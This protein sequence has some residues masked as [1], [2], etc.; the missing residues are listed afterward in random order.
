[1]E[2]WRGTRGPSLVTR[3][4]GLLAT[5]RRGR[6]NRSRRS[7]WRPAPPDAAVVSDLGMLG[8]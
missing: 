1:M 5:L 8:G 3:A 6:L 2:A 7:A 4:A